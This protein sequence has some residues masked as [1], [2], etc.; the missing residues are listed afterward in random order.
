MTLTVAE[1][2]KCP[3]KG[4]AETRS[5]KWNAVLI[6]FINYTCVFPAKTCQILSWLKVCWDILQVVYVYI[7]MYVCVHSAL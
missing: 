6:N 2:I 7:L 3:S 5:P 1:F 4:K